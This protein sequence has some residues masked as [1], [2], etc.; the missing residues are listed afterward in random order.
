MAASTTTSPVGPDTPSRPSTSIRRARRQGPAWLYSVVACYRNCLWTHE[1]LVSFGEIALVCLANHRPS[2]RLY[3]GS[4][5]DQD[6][7]NPDATLPYCPITFVRNPSLLS[8]A[9]A[10]IIHPLPPPHWG[11][12]P[13]TCWFPQ[14]GPQPSTGLGLTC[15]ATDRLR[16]S[17]RPSLVGRAQADDSLS[18]HCVLW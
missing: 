3:F 17:L 1:K 5:R 14:P 7:S 4:Y 2:R 9:P 13:P 6:L 16:I 8:L 10:I 15:Q 12:R 18:I 11:W